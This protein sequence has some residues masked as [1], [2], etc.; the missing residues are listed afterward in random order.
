REYSELTA[1]FTPEYPKVQRL[2]SQIDEVAAS[3]DR[4]RSAFAQRVTDDYK[5]ALNRK[6]LLDQAI[7]EQTKEFNQV[8]EKSI[9]YNILKREAETNKQLYDGLLQRLKEAS[10]SAGLKASNVRVVDPAEAPLRPAKP[11]MAINLALALIVGLSLG[12]GAALLQEHLDNTLKSPEDVQRYLHL[13]TLGVIPAASSPARK[14]ISFGK[15]AA[16]DK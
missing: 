3:I 12:L 4:E 10:V 9:Q 15:A 14:N 5:A 2:K 6:R 11:R 13:P 16:A 1:T 7:Q 8:S